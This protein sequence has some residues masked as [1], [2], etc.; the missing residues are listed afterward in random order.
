MTR[1]DGN[2]RSGTAPTAHR[3]AMTKGLRAPA[4]GTPR[5]SAPAC[6]APEA[7]GGSRGQGTSA[8][9][10]RVNCFTPGTLIATP[11]G[12]VAVETLKPGDQVVTRDNGPQDIRWIG[13]KRLDGP[14]LR[15]DPRLLPVLIRE[16]ALGPGLPERALS[17]S[18][19]HRVLLL[20]DHPG[21]EAGEAEV[22]VSARHLVGTRGIEQVAVDD[23]TY[24][25]FM[26]DRHEVVLSNGAWT[27]SFQP[28]D[29]ALEAVAD[30]AREEI[31]DLFPELRT[32]AT[33]AGFGAARPTL[34]PAAARKFRA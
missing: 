22:F 15:L 30:R 31:F 12:A 34:G 4:N 18:P 28:A 9:A 14:P 16:G 23:V 24:L 29:T 6:A 20:G 25:H 32:G 13:Q 5:R 1:Y 2:D 33:A 7:T 17:V 3:R 21:L 8:P 19:G 10:V 27:E 11:R 26:C